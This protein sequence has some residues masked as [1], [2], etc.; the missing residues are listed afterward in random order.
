MTAPA[1]IAP[2]TVVEAC[3][4]SAG[5]ADLGH[6]YDVA[7][8]VGL[9]D[10]PVR[11]AVR[12]LVTAGLAVQEGRG[13]RG[14]LRLSAEA[15]RRERNDTR[16]VAFAYRQDAGLA[17]W[18]SRWRLYSFSIPESRRARRD[19]LRAALGRLGAAAV[20]PAL[21]LSPHDL[22]DALA[23]EGVHP[24]TLDDLIV[25]TTDDLRLGRTHDPRA[26]AERLWPSPPV[27]DAY[28]ALD[29]TISGTA[30]RRTRAAAAGTGGA[31]LRTALALELAQAF[32]RALDLD[33][34]LP[35]ELRPADWSPPATRDRF[36]RAWLDL[37]A[38]SPD[39]AVFRAYR[40]DER[41]PPV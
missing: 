10:Q 4:D 16:F 39:L 15:L 12:R 3:F 20:A 13:R 31:A 27:E 8:A 24:G 40:L 26:I 14:T 34:L 35:A 37:A 30:E 17:P 28:R 21:Y 36:R 6:V 23:A 1:P 2:R 19:S 22:R 38:V 41:E 33:P 25:A 11:L 18:D 7:A 9:D 29:A 5:V 32:T